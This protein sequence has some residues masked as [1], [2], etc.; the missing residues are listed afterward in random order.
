LHF[1]TLFISFQLY[2]NCREL[3]KYTLDEK[4]KFA[5]GE[6]PGFEGELNNFQSPQLSSLSKLVSVMFLFYAVGLLLMEPVIRK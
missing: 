4:K 1:L 3:H 5:Q 6:G 2:E